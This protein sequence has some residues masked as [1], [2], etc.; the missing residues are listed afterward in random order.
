MLHKSSHCPVPTCRIGTGLVSS[1]SRL[2]R[3]SGLTG[4]RTKRVPGP[5]GP[6][7]GKVPAWSELFLGKGPRQSRLCLVRASGTTGTRIKR[8]LGLTQALSIRR[9]PEL[10][11]QRRESAP[12]RDNRGLQRGSSSRGT[13]EKHSTDI[14]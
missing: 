11:Q 2:R 13:G 8:V 5:S 6:C 4:S 7:L 14:R 3:T 1:G 9:A 10:T 12:S